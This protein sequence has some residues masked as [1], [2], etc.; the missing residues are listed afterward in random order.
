MFL[1]TVSYVVYCLD[2]DC[3]TVLVSDNH[4]NYATT[5]EAVLAHEKFIT[6]LLHDGINCASQKCFSHMPGQMHISLHAGIITMCIL[7]R[8][9]SN[10][11]AT[12]CHFIIIQQGMSVNVNWWAG[13]VAYQL[14]T[15]WFDR[16]W[17]LLLH[18]FEHRFLPFTNWSDQLD[19]S[20]VF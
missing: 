20:A 12:G 1:Y 4:K 7:K 18:F 17:N 3:C 6:R 10:W 5:N 13:R 16:F 8:L 2:I 15:R 14:E 9:V 11:Y 19:V